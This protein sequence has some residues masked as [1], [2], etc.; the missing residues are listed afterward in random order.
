MAVK[1]IIDEVEQDVIDVVRTGF[2][3]DDTEL[4]PNSES[5]LTYERGSQKKGKKLKTCVLYV[6]IRNSVALTEKH[7]SITMGRIYTAFTKAVVKIA[8][9]HNGHTRNII[10][11]RVMIVFP[12]ANCFTNA[13]NCA[14]SINHIAQFIINKKFVDVDFKC[15]IGIDYGTLRVIKVG[16]QRNGVERGENKGLVWVGYPAN[17]ASRLTDKAN[18]VIKETYYQV[19]MYPMNPAQYNP[20]FRSIF[21]GTNV[22][23]QPF[24]L[25]TVKTVDMSV[26]EFADSI[27]QLKDGSMYVVGG[28]LISFEKKNRTTS[29]SPILMTEEVYKGFSNANSTRN[30]VVKKQWTVQAG[31]IDNVANKI[32]GS[33]LTWKL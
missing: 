15:G 6:D 12:S 33:N 2:V 9:H 28:K 5:G 31:K 3:Y 8:R 20:L 23:A 29:F 24:Y 4:V 25:S 18:K 32:Y 19:S 26:E 22:Q 27:R 13:V 17:V 16:I 14:I 7:Q 1:G 21:Q 11:D 30:D 10:G